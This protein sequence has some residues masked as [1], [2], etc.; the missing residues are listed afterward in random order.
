MS[1]GSYRLDQCFG[2]GTYTFRIQE[3]SCG[4]SY[5]PGEGTFSTPEFSSLGGRYF[6]RDLVDHGG[7]SGVY[8]LEQFLRG[9]FR[10]EVLR[11]LARK[12]R[13]LR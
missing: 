4:E 9:T 7:V 3:T 11:G 8:K 2:E 5:D 6:A 10:Q 12:V 1:A 13:Q